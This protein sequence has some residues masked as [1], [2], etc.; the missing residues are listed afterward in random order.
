MA[1][2]TRLSSSDSRADILDNASVFDLD[3]VRTALLADL[4]GTASGYS[5]VRARRDVIRPQEGPDFGHPP[6]ET[7]SVE[8]VEVR[9]D[10]EV[11]H[12]IAPLGGDTSAEM[13]AHALEQLQGEVMEHETEPWPVCPEH[14]HELRPVP[15]GD[16][17]AWVC[18]TTEKRI[19]RFG[20]IA[21]TAA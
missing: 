20:E 6:F 13:L 18:P 14:Y 2:R 19:G 16:W 8:G 3:R 4:G 10:D 11:L 17:V 12:W 9:V 15:D 1:R 7:D 21:A 5:T